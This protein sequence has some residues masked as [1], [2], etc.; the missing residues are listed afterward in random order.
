MP[1]AVHWEMVESSLWSAACNLAVLA[2]AGVVAN[3]IYRRFRDRMT[4]RQELLDD[5]DQFSLACTSR[6]SSTRS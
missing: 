3:L 5:I 6:A 2:I 4:A 1:I